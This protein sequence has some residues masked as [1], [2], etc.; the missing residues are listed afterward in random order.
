MA[1]APA[2][3]LLHLLGVTRVAR[4]TGLDRAG[5][6]VACA[7]RPGG[8]V[9]QVTNGKGSTPEEAAFGAVM[10]AA[11]LW[12]A[13]QAPISSMRFGSLREL[14]APAWGPD[15]LGPVGPLWSPALRIGWCE[16]C[17]IDTGEAV[18][19][20]AQAVRCPPAAGPSLGPI[21]MAWT[22]NGMGAHPVYEKALTH[23]LLEAIERDQL[24][25][26]LP[27]GW[28]KP[29]VR[30]RRLSPSSLS[31]PLSRWVQR[32]GHEGLDAHL[33]DLTPR[34]AIGLP[35][36]GALLFDREGGPVPLA[37]GYACRF[38]LEQALFGALFEAA[39]S[40]LTDI[41]GARD[42]IGPADREAAS[43]L[44][45]WCEAAPGSSPERRASANTGR[46]SA[47]LLRLLH[48]AGFERVGVIDLATP[49]LGLAVLKVL[50]PG[51]KRSAL[52]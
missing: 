47:R 51:L 32:L 11:E 46:S 16:A 28:T 25:R 31:G 38:T 39:Q 3:K 52:L 6:E 41:H 42:D 35:L 20:P 8:H 5:V 40:R 30:R 10:E 37:A 14:G 13:E 34:R 36:A 21:V 43:V 33:F 27:E 26:A 49:P 17:R 2:K 50:V 18:W 7:I 19:V 48:A 1:A 24:D 9:L 22:S 29:E 44:R 4:I 12:A 45:A 23:A 15:L